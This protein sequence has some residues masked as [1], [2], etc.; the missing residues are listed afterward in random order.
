MRNPTRL[1]MASWVCRLV[2]GL[3]FIFGAVAPL[4]AQEAAFEQANKLYEQGKYEEAA[5]AYQILAG[6]NQIS[7]ALQFNLGNAWFKASQIGRAI[8]AWR[9]AERAAPRDPDVRFNLSFARKQ[10]SGGSTPD[11]PWPKRF[12]SSVTLNGWSLAGVAAFWLFFVLLALREIRPLWRRPLRLPAIFVGL[13]SLGLA[14]M[15]LLAYNL[16]RIIGATVVV[17]QAI[18]RYGPLEESQVHY[19]LRD[20]SEVIVL[21]EKPDVRGQPAWIQ[22]QDASRRLG[23]VKHDQLILIR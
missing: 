18:V 23:W 20:G 2:S 17:P 1:M 4:L 22:V 21:D 13:L 10:I 5:S 9:F 16:T 8:A 19:Q 14:V 3:S 6:T 15:A 12:L 11:L 7:P